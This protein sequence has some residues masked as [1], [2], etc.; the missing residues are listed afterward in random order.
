MI[1][2][3]LTKH[4]APILIFHCQHYK[5]FSKLINQFIRRYHWKKGFLKQFLFTWVLE[6][7]F[8]EMPNISLTHEL[9]KMEGNQ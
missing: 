9:Q 6:I 1:D 5:T 4:L 2:Y 8:H 3:L 7:Y